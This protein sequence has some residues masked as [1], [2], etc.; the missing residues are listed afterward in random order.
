ME[1][2][3][4]PFIAQTLP[5]ARAAKYGL[6]G[7]TAHR[8]TVRFRPDQD[9]P[10][11]PAP[12]FII[13][14]G[15]SGT[16]LLG[17]IFERH[18][19]V[20]YYFEPYHAWAAIDPWADVTNLYFNLPARFVME[21][22]D[23]SE[24]KA[25]RFRRFFRARRAATMKLVVEKTPH[26]AVRI[27]YIDALAPGAKFIHSVRDGV[28][29]ARSISRLATT[30]R[31]RITGR[32]L[33]QW[34]GIEDAKWKAIV[35]DGTRTGCF[36]AELSQLYTHEARGAYEWL[37]SQVEVDRRRDL[38]GDRLFEL[39][40]DSL[41]RSPATE[42]PKICRFLGLECSDEWLG[43]A[44]T[45]IDRPKSPPCREIV[46]PPRICRAFNHYQSR[47]RFSG[48]ARP[49]GVQSNSRNAAAA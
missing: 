12:A 3:N 19:G 9:E 32:T 10:L 15:R 4:F 18:P 25:R 37:I 31:Y 48:R 33:N 43:W 2:R 29:V 20:R 22:N 6:L 34:W 42:L 39:T 30:N 38:L 11:S 21:S 46:L 45:I 28:D 1:L 44:M 36:A 7:W 24:E 17:Q 26:N 5:L 23:S 49:D 14:C 47:W 13:G 41:V 16:T 27:G 35:R 8:R 40:Y